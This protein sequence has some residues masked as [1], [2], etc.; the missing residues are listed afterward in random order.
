MIICELEVFCSDL[1]CSSYNMNNVSD[2][3]VLG[4]LLQRYGITL[5]SCF[6]NVQQVSFLM[7]TF[8]LCSNVNKVTTL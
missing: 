4:V 5:I 2:A 3:S 6:R 8:W 7:N 1:H